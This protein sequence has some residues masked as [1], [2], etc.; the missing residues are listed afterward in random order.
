MSDLNKLGGQHYEIIRRCYNPSCKTYSSYGAKGIKVC[1][2]W[3]DREHFR[4]WAISNG[5]KRGM[6]LQRYDTSKDYEPNNCYWGK[7]YIRTADGV[8]RKRKKNHRQEMK[9]MSGMDKCIHNEIVRAYRAMKA[10]CNNPN[11]EKYKNYGGRGIKI[12]D[13]WLGKDGIFAFYKWSIDNGWEKG[14]SIDRIDNDK[15]YSPSNCRWTDYETQANNK[16]NIV[17]REYCGDKL[18]VAQIARR[19]EVNYDRLLNLVN[20]GKDIEIAVYYLQEKEK[21]DQLIK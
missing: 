21:L 2:E 7:K 4:M 9:N 19:E 18:S 10:R 13:E 15:G 17:L 11:N 8:E 6:R 12:C 14:L 5:Y 16:R 1:E 20:Q 3:H